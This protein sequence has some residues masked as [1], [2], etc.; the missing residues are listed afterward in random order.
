[1]WSETGKIEERKVV[2]EEQELEEALVQTGTSAQLRR[3]EIAHPRAFPIV[4][5]T[6]EKNGSSLMASLVSLSLPKLT[7]FVQLSLLIVTAATSSR[8]RWDLHALLSGHAGTAH[9]LLA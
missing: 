2:K 1:M 9:S 8:Y 6:G 4:V 5:R 3:T 7:P